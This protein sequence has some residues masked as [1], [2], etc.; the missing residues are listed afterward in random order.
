MT[1][2]LP[3]SSR[4]PRLSRSSRSARPI[5]DR[6][7]GSKF[8][9]SRRPRPTLSSTCTWW[10]TSGRAI[11]RSSRCGC[12]AV[13]HRPVAIGRLRQLPRPG[14]PDLM[15]APGIMARR[16][17]MFLPPLVFRERPARP[18]VLARQ[19]WLSHHAWPSRRQAVLPLG[20][21]IREARAKCGGPA[22]QVLVIK[23]Q[24]WRCMSRTWHHDGAYVDSQRREV[25]RGLG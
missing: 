17:R 22:H 18:W 6:T 9:K 23:H 12:S 2:R 21:Q 20:R 14:W 15:K 5:G 3:A 24:P 11:R 7:C 1:A 19:S 25:P 10:R 16:S 4:P 8:A 13:L